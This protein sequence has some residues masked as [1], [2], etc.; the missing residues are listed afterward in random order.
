MAAGDPPSIPTW[1]DGVLYR[2]RTEARHAYLFDKLGIKFRYEVQGFDIQGTWYLPDFVLFPALG[3]LWAEIKGD[4]QQDPRGIARWR[5]FAPWRPQPSR[6][7]L[8]IGTPAL[9]N[10]PHLIGGSEDASP[11]DAWEDDSQVWRPCPAGYHFD[12]AQPGR[13]GGKFAEDGCPYTDQEGF[14]QERL[15]RA[16]AAARSARF[17]CDKAA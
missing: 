11:S 10:S 14:G 2:S 3:M 6:G 12:F 8:I 15:E 13:F 17:P 9:D 1:Y 16:I 7:A 5:K 4:W